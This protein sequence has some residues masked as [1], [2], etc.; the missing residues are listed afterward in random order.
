M[1]KGDLAGLSIA[2]VVGLVKGKEVSPREVVEAVLRRIEALDPKVKAYITVMGEEALTEA[3]ALE[4]ALARGGRPGPLAGATISLKDLCY[5]KGVRTTGGSKVLADFVPSYDGTLVAR[6][7]RAGAI[8][9]GKNHMHEF[10]AASSP[11][12]PFYG[13][14]RNPW[15]LQRVPGG[16]SSGSGI[17][18]I[19]DLCHGSIGSDGGGSIRVPSSFCGIVGLKP[20]FGR[21]SKCGV[22]PGAWSLDYVGPMTKTVEDT[23]LMLKAIAGWDPKDPESSRAP[24]ADYPKALTGQVRG[25]RLGIPKSYFF[26]R[27]DGHVEAAVRKAIGVLEELGA[28]VVEVRLPD[29][30]G[31]KAV[32]ILLAGEVAA[33]HEKW[34]RE[35]PGDY[36]PQLRSGL[37]SRRL[38]P[39]TQYLKAQRARRAF[40]VQ[41][42]RLFAPID[43]LLTPTTPTV[44]PKIGEETILINGQKEEIVSAMLR[45]TWP[46]NLTGAPAIT[47]P[48]GFTRRGLPIGLQIVGRPFDEATVLRVAHAYESHTEWHKR[49]PNL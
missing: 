21:V 7:R 30:E 44:A 1:P 15:D 28:K 35:R 19:A 11:E 2:E 18:V 46:F 38:V 26:E 12:N 13:T 3:E 8:I 6:L 24:V 31:M 43:A 41:F 49:R 16:S 32:F 20:P 45:F 34:L 33:F 9:I 14:A 23:A 5:T 47:V 25:L 39:A 29:M 22:I 37:E 40:N 4:K 27:L 48:C 17:A 10:A 42:S 36:S